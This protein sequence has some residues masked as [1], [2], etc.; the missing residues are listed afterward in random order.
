ML[1][2]EMQNPAQTLSRCNC[3]KLGLVDEF[4]D[5]CGDLP[6]GGRFEQHRYL[7]PSLQEVGI[8]MRRVEQERHAMMEEGLTDFQA[9]LIAQSDIND[10]RR[11]LVAA[12]EAEGFLRIGSCDNPSARSVEGGMEIERN[13]R[14]V[15]NYQ[16]RKHPRRKLRSEFVGRLPG[17]A[18]SLNSAMA[19]NSLLSYQ[20]YRCHSRS[21]GWA[22]SDQRRAGPVSSRMLQLT[23]LALNVVGSALIF[24]FAYP[25]QDGRRQ[26]IFIRL[27]RFA[28]LLVF[29]GFLLQFV[30]IL[31]EAP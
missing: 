23:G 8:G 27:S 20:R 4:S 13:E 21:R 29:C 16:N 30:A 19:E 26:A 28:I 15:F 18:T 25:P 2:A 6:A 24:M 3:E 5:A 1:Y 11:D 17:L 9:I 22:Y 12:D 10:R 14:F 31:Y 7:W